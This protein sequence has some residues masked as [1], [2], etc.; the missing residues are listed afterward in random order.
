[1]G[2]IYTLDILWHCVE[3]RVNYYKF[4]ISRLTLAH[5]SFKSHSE[6]TSVLLFVHCSLNL[7]FYIFH[8]NI[9][10]VLTHEDV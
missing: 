5:V 9:I 10:L 2:Y 4:I 6:R 3:F 8:S 1:M 7:S